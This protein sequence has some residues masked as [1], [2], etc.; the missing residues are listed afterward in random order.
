MVAMPLEPCCL[1]RV[2]LETTYS[3][4]TPCRDSNPPGRGPQGRRASFQGRP[5]G[6]QWN[7]DGSSHSRQQDCRT[8]PCI[9]TQCHP[10]QSW[11]LNL[12]PLKV[13]FLAQ[14]RASAHLA[15]ES[16]GRMA[17]RQLRAGSKGTAR[18]PQA[19]CSCRKRARPPLL[20][21]VVEQKCAATVS[22]PG[23]GSTEDLRPSSES[24]Q[25]EVLCAL[26]SS[27]LRQ[28][29][30]KY[31]DKMMV[32][33]AVCQAQQQDCVRACSSTSDLRRWGHLRG[34]FANLSSD[35]WRRGLQPCSLQDLKTE[36][37]R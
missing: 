19:Q 1:V 36:T 3:S 31:Q 18:G 37:R 17:L 28:C 13:E 12:T 14:E 33:A 30:E 25:G 34:V 5:R 20:R 24:C 32:H 11:S 9:E 22:L 29:E 23:R 4:S 10:N 16:R 35:S 21:A 2:T 26:S 8:Q 7:R 6:R 27:M 15:A